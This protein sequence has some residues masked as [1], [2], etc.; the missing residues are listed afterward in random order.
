MILAAGIIL[1]SILTSYSS[2]P[3]DAIHAAGILID[4]VRVASDCTISHCHLARCTN[5]LTKHVDLLAVSYLRL[6]LWPASSSPSFSSTLY[7]SRRIVQ[8]P[9]VCHLE[10][11]ANNLTKPVDL[12]T[13]SYSRLSLQPASS[14]PS[15][16]ST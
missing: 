7:S 6:S 5:N 12:L 3:T 15:F 9:T 14:S 11:C 10:S 2:R 1:T 13:A 16:S 8:L 4:I